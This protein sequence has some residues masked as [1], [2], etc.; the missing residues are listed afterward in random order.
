[1]RGKGA[2]VKVLPLMIGITPA[3]AGKS[4]YVCMIAQNKSGSPPP[5]RGKAPR[6][7]VLPHAV[8]ITPAYAGKSITS[9]LSTVHGKDHPRLC[10]EKE[11]LQNAKE[12]KEGSPPP[13]RGK[14]VSP[15]GKW[16]SSGIPPAYAGKRRTPSITAF[17]NE[18]P[19]R[20]CGEKFCNNQFGSPIQGSPPPMRGKGL[21]DETREYRTRITPAYAGKRHEMC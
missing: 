12:T 15:F 20:L 2:R 1:M 10:G 19:P 6:R 14:V 9:D 21:A 11:E 16:Y 4:T 3:Y 7:T 8:R 5:M 13:M 18:D 17:W